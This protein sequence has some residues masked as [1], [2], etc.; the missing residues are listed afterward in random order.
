[1]RA[2]QRRSP[3]VR[4]FD[5][6]IRK[7]LAIGLAL[8]LWYFLDAQVTKTSTA[9]IKVNVIFNGKRDSALNQ[10]YVSLGSLDYSLKAIQNADTQETLPSNEISLTLKGK[11]HLIERANKDRVFQVQYNML[12][13]VLRQGDD[14]FVKFQLSDLKHPTRPDSI[15][16]LLHSMSPP[17]VRV[18][19]EKNAQKAIA[20]THDNIDLSKIDA[21]LRDRITVA[22]TRFDPA[23]LN[24]LIPEARLNMISPKTKLFS[25]VFE[26]SKDERQ[27]TRQLTLTPAFAWLKL[28]KH[29]TATFKIEPIWL[30]YQLEN[31]PVVLD[32][33][34]VDPDEAAKYEV[35]PKSVNI[36]IRATGELD[37][38]LLLLV[39]D[40]NTVKPEWVKSCARVRVY[41]RQADLSKDTVDPRTPTLS[42]FKLNALD[43]ETP[44]R[45]GIDFRND[46]SDMVIQI[47]KK[48]DVK[49]D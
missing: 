40:N 47:V 9:P 33:Q 12:T 13:D 1:M 42:L 32:V 43:K 7:L 6:P 25:T 2:D 5:D 45:E 3:W 44:Y 28:V 30:N 46:D 16:D 27:I 19:L 41:L 31:V 34:G 23:T 10:I 24:L 37:R 17:T 29:P 21:T 39:K 38:A 35:S 11:Q 15:N 4:I 36:V 49:K 14:Y 18:L 20:L 48:K 8:L 26:A 22:S